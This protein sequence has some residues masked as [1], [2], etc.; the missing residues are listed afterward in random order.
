MKVLKEGKWNLPWSGTYNCPTCEAQL[1]VEETDV[2]AALYSNS[3]FSC[4]CPICHKSIS[5]PDKDLP[6]RVKEEI[7]RKRP[8]IS[9]GSPWD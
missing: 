8:Y 4:S 6:L 7:N 9:P 5:I 1:L 2:K 3:G